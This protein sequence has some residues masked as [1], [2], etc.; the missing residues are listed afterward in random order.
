LTIYN[1][2]AGRHGLMVG[3]TWWAL[4]MI[5]AVGYFA[6]L[7]RMFRGKVRLEGEGY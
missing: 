7:F 1:T 3:F 4:G 5:L 6:L 2:A